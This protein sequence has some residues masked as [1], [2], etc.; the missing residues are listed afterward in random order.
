M[1]R[2]T[3][4]LL[5]SLAGVGLEAAEPAQPHAI[6]TRAGSPSLVIP[7]A[8]NV[9]GGNGTYFRTQITLL[10]HAEQAVR[11][12]VRWIERDVATTAAPV[13]LDLPSRNVLIYEDF[14]G[15]V[16]RRD[17]L[18]S[19]LIRTVDAAG[20]FVPTGQLDA[21]A[22]IWTL[23]PGS[24]GTVSQSMFALRES[25]L[26]SNACRPAYIL[27][28]R[29]TDRHRANLGIVNL[30]PTAQTY[31]VD[32]VGT[33][34]STSFQVGLAPLSMKQVP[35]PDRTFGDFYLVVTPAT[36]ILDPFGDSTYAAYGSTVDN[37]S[38]DAWSVASTFGFGNL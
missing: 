27:G 23:Q 25:E 17:G 11:V 32:V 20:E 5:L 7:A 2:W 36:G 9:E 4:T 34:H 33:A 3:F 30:D 18:G 19:I 24:E 1:T 16:L 35:L 13:M 29:Q 37:L 28:M 8:G 22:R 31:D 26:L 10:N 14:V 12:S 6:T 38:G 15:Q 21:F